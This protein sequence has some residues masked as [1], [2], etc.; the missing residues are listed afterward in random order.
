MKFIIQNSLASRFYIDWELCSS[1]IARACARRES[2]I[3]PADLFRSLATDQ[4]Y[5]L[6]LFKADDEVVGA[7]VVIM[8]DHSLHIEALAG[9]FP[10]RWVYAFD[11]WLEAAAEAFGRQRATL[12]GRKGWVRKLRGLG[13][14]LGANGLLE[15]DY[16][17][18]RK[19]QKQWVFKQQPTIH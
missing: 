2:S 6:V 9:E 11:N 10:P 5:Q 13:W 19:Q 4:R 16:G 14:R 3:T 17:R 7:A 1:F 8:F 18:R 12:T 15:V